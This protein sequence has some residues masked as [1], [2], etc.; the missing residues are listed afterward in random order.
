ML[1]VV[2]D[3]LAVKGAE[4]AGE[5]LFDVAGIAPCVDQV[6]GGEDVGSGAGE[7]LGLGA[8]GQPRG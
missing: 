4:D 6:A 8:D 2:Q 7:V 5:G 3:E 1:S